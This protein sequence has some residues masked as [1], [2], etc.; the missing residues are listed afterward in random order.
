MSSYYTNNGSLYIKNEFAEECVNLLKEKLG[1]DEDYGDSNIDWSEDN[2]SGIAEII[3]EEV[4]GD[5][6][7]DIQTIADV[8]KERGIEISGDIEYYGSNDGHIVVRNNVV[9]DYDDEDYG[10][11]DALEGNTIGLEL[12]GKLLCELENFNG[13]NSIEAMKKLINEAKT[14]N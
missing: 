13:N 14:A 10:A 6:T 9:R 11:N 8:F 4:D 1:C 2:K 5:I 7:D 12:K 3:L